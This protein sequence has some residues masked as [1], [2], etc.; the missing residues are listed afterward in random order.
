MI[1]LY[2]ATILTWPSFKARLPWLPINVLFLFA[3]SVWHHVSGWIKGD[4]IVL[5]KL[6]RFALKLLLMHWDHVNDNFHR[7]N[8]VVQHYRTLA[9]CPRS[10]RWP[11]RVRLMKLL[12]TGFTH[13]LWCGISFSRLPERRCT[14]HNSYVPERFLIK[15]KTAGWT[16]EISQIV[17][18][19]KERNQGNFSFFEEL[20]N[21]ISFLIQL[22]T[23]ADWCNWRWRETA[24]SIAFHPLMAPHLSLFLIIYWYAGD[25]V[26]L[27]YWIFFYD[28]PLSLCWRITTDPSM[29]TQ[30]AVSESVCTCI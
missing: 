8:K 14:F 9:A 1:E 3:T 2:C 16:V 19:P 13:S 20:V 22:S 26:H 29:T 25:R 28:S 6:K 17:F 24:N 27:L 11:L 10:G 30:G 21:H 5:L 23:A 4:R 7:F 15:V 12:L 18:A